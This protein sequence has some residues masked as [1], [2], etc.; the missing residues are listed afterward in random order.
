[1]I[2]CCKIN[3]YICIFINAIKIYI[4]TIKMYI[5]TEIK[6]HCKNT[7]N[8]EIISFITTGESWNSLKSIKQNF[9]S[10]ILTNIWTYLI[11]NSL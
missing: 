9:S 5:K 2:E 10:Y 4:K 8:I 6:Q 3:K 11:Y 1:M 7:H